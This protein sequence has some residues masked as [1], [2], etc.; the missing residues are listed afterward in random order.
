MLEESFSQ[1]SSFV[2]NVD[3]RPKILVAT[4][5]IFSIAILHTA[6]AALFALLIGF[7]LVFT[8]QLPLE[9]VIKRLIFINGFIAFLW[10]FLP[11]STPG[12][13]L[14]QIWK[15]KGTWE[16]MYLA[17]LIT[18]KSNAILLN[19]IALIATNSIPVLGQALYSLRVPK[20]LVFLLLIS[21]R[22]LNLILD[23]YTR[24]FTAAKVRGFHSGTNMH[25][26]RTFGNLMAMV[27]IKSY[28]RS[29]RVY[30][31]MLLRGFKGKFYSLHKLALTK[32]DIIFAFTILIIISIVL[33]LNF[34][35]GDDLLKHYLLCKLNLL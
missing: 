34:L 13:P 19:I 16:G 28:D 12:E 14:F 2:H 4:F 7:I 11:F 21:Y 24:L 8:A 15:L 33:S 3:P 9:K 17:G 25:T 27:L 22:Y 26:Y 31:A 20:K 30:Q 6:T 32:K 1:G 35:F 18:L 29:K 5:F 10:L 23:E